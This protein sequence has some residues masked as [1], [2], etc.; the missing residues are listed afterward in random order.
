VKGILQT[1]PFLPDCKVYLA[2]MMEKPICPILLLVRG[3]SLQSRKL[4]EQLSC[5]HGSWRNRFDTKMKWGLI[6]FTKI[7][8]FDLNS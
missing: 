3:W 8:I 2:Y 5:P 1:L 4:R 6:P 7:K